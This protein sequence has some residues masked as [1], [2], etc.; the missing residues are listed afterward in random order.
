M[1]HQFANYVLRCNDKFQWTETTKLVDSS[2]TLWRNLI[3]NLYFD[4]KKKSK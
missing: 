1:W 4:E 2:F 3:I